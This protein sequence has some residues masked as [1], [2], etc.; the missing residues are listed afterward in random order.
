MESQKDLK[1]LNRV[2]FACE[3]GAE[4]LWKDGRKRITIVYCK[5]W[6]FPQS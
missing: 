2:E 6:K 1:E 5:P 3:E 4:L